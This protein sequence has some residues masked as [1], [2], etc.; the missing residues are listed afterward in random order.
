[1]S[2][3]NMSLRIDAELKDAFMAAAK[4]MDRNGSQLIRDFMRQTVERQHNAWFREQVNAGRQQLERG[5]V[6]PHDM[7]EA[8]AAAWRDEMMKK[9]A[10]K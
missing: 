6:L 8:S 5:E 2:Q 10:G 9:A 7:V 4:S 1:M 3:V